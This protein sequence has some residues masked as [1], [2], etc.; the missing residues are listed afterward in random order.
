MRWMQIML[1][2]AILAVLGKLLLSAD[3]L[4]KARELR[5]TVA[6]QQWQNQQLRERN[7][8]LEAEVINLKRGSEAAEERARTDLG[9]IGKNETF[10]Q[11]IPSDD[12][13]F[14]AD[15]SNR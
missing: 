14:V 4:Q 15:A 13:K 2:I 12:K 11:V 7:E 10:F 3:G 5:A 8:S 6:A 9:M 1:V